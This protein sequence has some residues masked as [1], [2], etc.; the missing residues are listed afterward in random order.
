MRPTRSRH[1]YAIKDP[2]WTPELILNE[3]LRTARYTEADLKR[4]PLAHP[5]TLPHLKQQ[6]VAAVSSARDLLVKL[7]PKEIGCLYLDAKGQPCT[8]DPAAPDFPRL[9]RHYGSLKG[10]WP[11]FLTPERSPA[12]SLIRPA[13]PKGKKGR[14][15]NPEFER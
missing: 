12:M 2:G 5:V 7:P 4:L 3:A 14:G 8:P 6:W 10:A 15:R 1:A 9:P 11:S 13:P